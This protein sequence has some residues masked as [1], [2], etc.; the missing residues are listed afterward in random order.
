[1]DRRVKKTKKAIR[2]AFFVLAKTN[3]INKIK[4]SEIS[5]IADINRKT[6]YLHYV[7]IYS[8]LEEIEEEFIT[9]ADLLKSHLDLRRLKTDN[10]KFIRLLFDKLE[11]AMIDLEPIINTGIYSSIMRRAKQHFKKLLIEDYRRM[12]GENIDLLSLIFTFYASG[13]IDS[14]QEW[15]QKR[16][17]INK[18]E[19]IDTVA[20][21]L[22]EGSE[23]INMWVNK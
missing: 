9:Q 2:D 3:D 12:G 10:K 16:E 20:L 14:F 21:L 23:I 22:S 15:Y 18:D 8:L 17:I 1:M 19:Y 5:Q 6:F 7:D 4:V 11:T 13:V